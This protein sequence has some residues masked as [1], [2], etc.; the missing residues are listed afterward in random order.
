MGLMKPFLSI[1]TLYVMRLNTQSGY[2][3]G[4]LQ[5]FSHLGT[6]SRNAI[7][8]YE[9][10]LSDLLKWVVFGGK[11]IPKKATGVKYANK[12]LLCNADPFKRAN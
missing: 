3:T 9:S 1:E 6:I 10:K 4:N 2:I 12:A 11:A 5:R 8:A 7:F